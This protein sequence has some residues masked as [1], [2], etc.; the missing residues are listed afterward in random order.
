MTQS[1]L[2]VFNTFNLKQIRIPFN[3]RTS[4]KVSATTLNTKLTTNVTVQIIIRADVPIQ[5]ENI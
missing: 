1:E 5:P 4:V 3:Y 2:L